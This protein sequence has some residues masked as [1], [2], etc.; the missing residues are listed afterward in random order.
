[1]SLS[2]MSP[3]QVNFPDYVES[4]FQ[5]ARALAQKNISVN[6]SERYFMRHCHRKVE[7]RLSYVEKI[8]LQN[9]RL[10]LWT[11]APDEHLTEEVIDLSLIKSSELC[12]TIDHDG[13][14]Y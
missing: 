1:M 4:A 3:S 11:P 8:Y 2:A 13:D 7:K 9:K 12:K 6:K 14:S 10:L 5:V